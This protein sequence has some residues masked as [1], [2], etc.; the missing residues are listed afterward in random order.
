MSKNQLRLTI[1]D[2]QSQEVSITIELM[3]LQNIANNQGEEAVKATIFKVFK[4]LVERIK[5]PPG[6]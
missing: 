3:A 5:T 2:A 1:T 6:K 4:D